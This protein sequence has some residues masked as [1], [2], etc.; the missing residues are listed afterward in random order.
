MGGG[1]ARRM[2]TSGPSAACPG[3][4]PPAP[5]TPD[6]DGQAGEDGGVCGAAAPAGRARGAPL[7]VIPGG[8]GT[9]T[10]L[11]DGDGQA[12][13]SVLTI[14]L[15]GPCPGLPAGPVAVAGD[16]GA[17]WRWSSSRSWWPGWR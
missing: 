13:E 12:P 10:E 8:A 1:P 11:A 9:P 5:V 4:R 16:G 15:P 7:R 14:S 6:D 2:A 17:G 3:S